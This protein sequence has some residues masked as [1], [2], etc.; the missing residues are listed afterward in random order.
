MANSLRKMR[1]QQARQNAALVREMKDSPMMVQKAAL[2]RNGVTLADLEAEYKRGFAAARADV[3]KFCFH[4]I[5]AAVLITL[6]E[7]GMSQQQAVETLRAIDRQ[8]VACIDDEDITK[9]AYEK[10]GIELNWDDPIDRIN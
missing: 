4:T 5:Y 3:E 2:F 6:R 10:T 9:E 1:R 7:S 8:V